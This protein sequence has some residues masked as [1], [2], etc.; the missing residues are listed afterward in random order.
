M[1]TPAASTRY[2]RAP[3]ASDDPLSTART[4]ISD[5]YKD[6][7]P[8]QTLDQIREGK[9]KKAEAEADVIRGQFD[10]IISN[11]RQAGVGRE[12]R[13]RA[14][15]VSS[16]LSGSDFASSAAQNTEDKNNEILN[17]RMQERDSKINA[18]MSGVD[19]LASKEYQTQ[20]D[21][22]LKE[23]EGNLDAQKAFRDETKTRA[24]D[25]IKGL[26]AGGITL[27]GLK[28]TDPTSYD[29]LLKEYGGAPYELEGVW[30]ANLPDQYQTKFQ[31][32]VVEGKNGN[33]ELLRYG[34]NPITGKTESKK[35]DLGTSYT[36]LKGTKTVTVDGKLYKQ[37]SDGSLTYLAGDGS[38][39][40]KKITSGALTLNESQIA[41]AADKLN[42]TKGADGYVDPTAY[43]AAAA[44][45]VAGKG[46]IQ[47]FVKYFS[48]NNYVNPDNDWLP[49]YLRA[50]KKGGATT[51][52]RSFSTN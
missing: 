34:Y 43:Q 44:E 29:A 36:S 4:A 28:N 7:A 19:E 35:Y 11:E 8:A 31:D 26:A 6:S 2:E 46:L 12:G 37:N 45:W 13:T 3:V 5:F 48:P 33:A 15:S 49:Q 14:L 52:D 32:E 16:G 22:K 38:G 21:N 51:D 23:L 39:S 9:Q 27:D 24:T 41:D 25:Y 17:A 40:T 18:I 42:K 20:R 30:N 50:T 47:D 10:K 1:T